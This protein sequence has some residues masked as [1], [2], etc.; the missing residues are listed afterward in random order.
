M[1]YSDDGNVANPVTGATA[2]SYG[3]SGIVTPDSTLNRVFILG[4]TAAQAQSTSYTIESFNE[5]GFTPVSSITVNNIAG[6][7]I[8]LTRW[9]ASG[10][11]VATAGANGGAIGMLYLLASPTFVSGAGT[12]SAS[13]AAA[14]ERVQRR[15]KPLSKRAIAKTLRPKMPVT[16]R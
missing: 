2:G 11:A 9:G 5:T 16:G 7:P 15:W 4:Q 14:E 8:G 12:S 13:P 3:A 6:T 10:L 1:I